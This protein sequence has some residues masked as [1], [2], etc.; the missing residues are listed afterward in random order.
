MTKTNEFSFELVDFGRL[1][2]HEREHNNWRLLDA[3]LARF[4]SVTNLQGVWENALVIA[5]DDVYAD[6]DAGT[7]WTALIAHTSHSTRTF[8]QE[9]AAHPTYWESYTVDVTSGGAWATATSYQP[10][11][12]LSNS[13]RF[14]VTTTTFTSSA[15][16][17]TD[18][19]NGN[20]VTLIDVSTPL[21]AAVVAELAAQAAQAAQAAN[22][23]D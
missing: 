12:F 3:V 9:R 21:A 14:G 13:N 5:A 20:I 23:G 16:Y 6:P 2:W 17:N 8:A 4:V 15:S 1:P 22:T 11:T 18:V 19:T 7:L 10:N